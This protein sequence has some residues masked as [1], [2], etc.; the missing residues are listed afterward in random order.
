MEDAMAER[1]DVLILGSGQA[2]NPLSS[3]FVKAGKRVGLIEGAEVEGTCINYGC[4]PTKRMV[5]RAARVAGAT[6][7]RVGCPRGHRAR[8]YGR[9]A[10]AQAKD[11]RAVSNLEREALRQ[12]PAGAGTGRTT[13]R[14]SERDRSERDRGRAQGRRRAPAGGGDDRDQ[15]RGSSDGA[16]YTGAGW[17]PVSGQREPDGAGR[18][19]RTSA[20]PGWR[21]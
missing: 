13:V 21:V 11:R 3:E 2:G 12:W 4:T 7:G 6:R 8:E 18:C 9:G 19:A 20:D 16:E 10:G 14:R 17:R 1:Y 5:A 15:H